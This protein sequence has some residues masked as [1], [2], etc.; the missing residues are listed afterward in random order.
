MKVAVLTEV[1]L[2]QGDRLCYTPPFATELKGRVATFLAVSDPQPRD[3]PTY[4]IDVRFE[5]VDEEAVKSLPS[6]WLLL[7]PP[8]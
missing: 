7:M 4:W 3:N 1:E 8:V 6:N 5:D 2:K